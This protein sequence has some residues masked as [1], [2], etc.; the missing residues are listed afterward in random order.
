MAKYRHIPMTVLGE[1]LGVAQ[2]LGGQALFGLIAGD[3]ALDRSEMAS[4]DDPG[5][6]GPASVAWRIHGDSAMFI[7]GLRSLLFQSLHPLAMAG[8]DQHSDYREDPW[9]RLNRTGRFIG[10]TTFGST[11]TAETTI[12][13][14]RRVHTRVRGVDPKGREYSA[15]DPHLLRWV[16]IVEVDSFL[17]AFNRYGAGRLTDAEQDRYVAEM[18]VVAEALGVI[19]A[20]DSVASLRDAIDSYRD[21]LESTA[22]ARRGLRFLA[23]PPDLPLVGRAPY[24]VI[25]SA[26]AASLPAYVRRMLMLPVPPL[27]EPLM[28]RPAA[29]VLTRSLGWF[30]AGTDRDESLQERLH[31][32]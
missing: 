18:A 15:N 29:T 25:F 2:R 28:V 23:V 24:G 31:R 8:V 27:A 32:G 22:A 17:D 5:L 12:E 30:M 10:A 4:I 6:F 21:E 7:G 9:G 11:A 26:A 16:H 3:E 14:V 20:P 13:M 19:D 1:A